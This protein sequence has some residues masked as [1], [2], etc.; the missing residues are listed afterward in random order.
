[1]ILCIL[2]HLISMIIEFSHIFLLIISC[3]RINMHV[4][5]NNVTTSQF[6][7]HFS[8]LVPD[9]TQDAISSFFIDND[10]NSVRMMCAFITTM[11]NW[12]IICCN[13]SSFW[14]TNF[15]V[16]KIST[17]SCLIC[18]MVLWIF[19]NRT[20]PSHSISLFW[21]WSCLWKIHRDFV[22]TLP[23]PVL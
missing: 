9:T 22:C 21:R 7:C 11:V 2:W 6:Q 20:C 18:W 12:M 16:S 5:D 8:F 17:C 15:T 4:I 1:M 19:L 23:G 10:S 13:L 3:G 14:S